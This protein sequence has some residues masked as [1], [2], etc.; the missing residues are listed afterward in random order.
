MRTEWLNYFLDIAKSGSLHL[1][2]EKFYISQPALG[3]AIAS[4]ERELGY[5]LFN[6]TSSGM[7][8]TELG[9]KTVPIAQE[10]LFQLERC[11][12]IKQDFY[13]EPNSELSGVLDIVTVPTIGTG[14]LPETIQ[15]F[16]KKYPKIRLTILETNTELGLE[17]LYKKQSDLG[18][19]VVFDDAPF[20]EEFTSELLWEEQLFAF[21][22]KDNELARKK[23]ISLETLKKC[24]LAIM[25]FSQD[26][27]TTVEQMIDDGESIPH[28]AL[29]TNNVA[30]LREFVLSTDSIALAHVSYILEKEYQKYFLS[31]AIFVPV[32]NSMPSRFISI[33]RNN[34]E[35]MPLI[36]AFID[37]LMATV[38]ERYQK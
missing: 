16:G 13:S 15:A 20:P 35:K 23:S 37:E 11:N 25:S 22:R 34:S 27:F 5:P 29:R 8:L 31:G 26:D 2:A 21:M 3:K 24:S 32:L 6:R 33:Y 28:I 7:R 10:I 36:R 18:V 19:L 4:L 30:L 14:I 38:R 12:K 17:Q 1:S 9:E